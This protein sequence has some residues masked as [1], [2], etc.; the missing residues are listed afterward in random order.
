MKNSNNYNDFDDE[1]EDDGYSPT[2]WERAPY[3]SEED[4]RDRMEDQ[5]SY[6]DYFE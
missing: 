4:Y 1:Y 6:L 2:S 5:E 3:E